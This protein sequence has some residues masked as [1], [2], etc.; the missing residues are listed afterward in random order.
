M[1]IKLNIVRAPV[2]RL[3]VL[4]SIQ[5]AVREELPPPLKKPL[6]PIIPA[7]SR[8][9][10]R[11]QFDELL[12]RA[13]EEEAPIR[14]PVEVREL[15]SDDAFRERLKQ[16]NRGLRRDDPNFIRLHEKTNANT[17]SSRKKTIQELQQEARDR[18]LNFLFTQ[19]E[20]EAVEPLPEE[21]VGFSFPYPSQSSLTPSSLQENLSLVGGGGAVGGG[22]VYA[23]FE[24]QKVVEIKEPPKRIIENSPPARTFTTQL[25]FETGAPVIRED[26]PVG[27]LPRSET[28]VITLPSGQ[29]QLVRKLKVKE[30]ESLFNREQSLLKQKIRE[31]QQGKDTRDIDA[32]LLKI[33]DLKLQQPLQFTGIGAEEI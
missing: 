28:E 4:P 12:R 8:P 33:S 32:E 7:S 10:S 29:P 22:G 15:S 27:R 23:P 1:K 11:S 25:S 19:A 13:E 31:N 17:G 14:S 9:R 16:H 18:G 5:E 20:V 24:P 2:E 26:I 21:P 3:N 6:P 30:P